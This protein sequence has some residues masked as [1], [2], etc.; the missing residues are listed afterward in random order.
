MMN[1]SRNFRTT[2]RNVSSGPG[3]MVIEGGKTLN[4]SGATLNA[5]RNTL[6]APVS[7]LNAHFS[8]FREARKMRKGVGNVF[9][10]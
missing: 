3:D 6:I 4:A 10:G 7:M 2:G 1:A 9:P 8:L 5:P